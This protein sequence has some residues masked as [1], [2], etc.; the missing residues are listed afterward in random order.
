EPAPNHAQDVIVAAI[1]H[2]RDEL[3]QRL[4]REGTMDGPGNAEM[5]AARVVA[6]LGT[7]RIY[8]PCPTLLLRPDWGCPPAEAC[9]S[10]ERGQ[11]WWHSVVG[12]WFALPLTRGLFEKGGRVSHW[13]KSLPGNGLWRF[14]VSRHFWAL[15]SKRCACHARGVCHLACIETQRFPRAE[16]EPGRR[17]EGLGGSIGN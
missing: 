8:L 12:E 6:R 7:L 5:V 14:S 11:M 3:R 10:R 1:R 9:L 13:N 16:D 2:E 4:G 15:H 17:R